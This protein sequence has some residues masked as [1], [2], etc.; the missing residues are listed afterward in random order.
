[1]TRQ[2]EY[3]NS[4]N[5]TDFYVSVNIVIVLKC[6]GLANYYRQLDIKICINAMNQLIQ[7]EITQTNKWFLD[8]LVIKAV[9]RILLYCLIIMYS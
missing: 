8:L 7:N 4:S 5:S 9:I 2:I 1:M 3:I 6:T